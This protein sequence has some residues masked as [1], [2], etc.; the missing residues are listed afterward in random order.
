F[1]TQ[2]SGASPGQVAAALEMI[3]QSKRPVFFVGHGVTLSEASAE[4]TALARKLG[5][6]V[7][8]SPNGFGCFDMADPLSLG[9]IGRNGAYPANEAGRRADL[10]I[11]VGAR[12]DD[13][14]A[15][16]WLPGY[17]WNFPHTKLVHVDV[18]PEEIG[19]NYPPDLGVLADA[20]TFLRQ[21][22]AELERRPAGRD[23]LKAWHADI[24]RWQADWEAHTRPNFAIHASPI[25][26]ERV[27]ADC[28]K[29][30]PET[31]IL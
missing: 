4:L 30:L 26:P 22:L 15:S 13:R 19:R 25:R 9:F 23:V 17:S 20:R 1:G 12:F 7:I 14:S 16:S 28:Q 31:A 24:R 21:L 29:V 2:R 11:A 10:V 18:D 8:S 3:L 27:V 5:I 6:P